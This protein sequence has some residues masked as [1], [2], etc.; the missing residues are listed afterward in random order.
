MFWNNQPDREALSLVRK[1]VG[2]ITILRAVETPYPTVNPIQSNPYFHF[3]F[4]TM[5]RFQIVLKYMSRSVQGNK[6]SIA[7]IAICRKLPVRSYY[8]VEVLS[9]HP[10][11]GRF[12][13][14]SAFCSEFI[15]VTYFERFRKTGLREALKHYFTNL[16]HSRSQEQKNN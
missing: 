2:R 12:F 10:C 5:T 4:M 16:A 8:K 14:F 7:L 9:Y 3:F 13:S 6:L 15:Y 1:G 11:N